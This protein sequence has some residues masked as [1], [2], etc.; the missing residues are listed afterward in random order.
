MTPT[1]KGK[2]KGI[3]RRH[4]GPQPKPKLDEVRNEINVTPLVDVCLVLLIIMMVVGPMLARGKEVQLPRTDHHKETKD[5]REAIVAIDQYGKIYVDKDE[6]RDIAEMTDKVQQA[7]K[8]LEAENRSMGSDA[9]RSG[10]QRV[11]LKVDRSV[12]Y[13]KVKP[14]IVALH[15]MGAIGIDLG[16]NERKE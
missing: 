14:V 16:T 1:R 11:L 2:G 13:G 8:K 6:A 3:K 7:W 4:L 5:N 15:E 9:D 12:V 10:E